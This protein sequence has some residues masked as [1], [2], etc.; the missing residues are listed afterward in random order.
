MKKRKVPET[1]SQSANFH[2]GTRSEYLAHFV[3]SSFGTSVPV[4]HPEDTGI[5]LHCTLTE[6]VG[7]RIWPVEY[8]MV[9]VK[10]TE[11]PWD[12]SSKKSVEQLFKVPLPV[13]FCIVSKKELRLRVYT[14]VNRLSV[15]EK[16][17]DELHLFPGDAHHG[18]PR[19]HGETNKISLGEPIL[20]FTINKIMDPAFARNAKQILY[21]A[22]REDAQQAFLRRIGVPIFETSSHTANE[23]RT[24]GRHGIGRLKLSPEQKE[25]FDHTLRIMLS[26]LDRSMLVKDT[27]GHWRLGLLRRHLETKGSAGKL[28]KSGPLQ[29]TILEYLREKRKNDPDCSLSDNLDTLFD[30]II[31]ALLDEEIEQQDRIHQKR[32]EE[33]EVDDIW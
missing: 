22:V 10:S 16:T 21:R 2:E 19:S 23:V 26:W 24:S 18:V 32:M 5:D 15:L 12:F 27:R 33:G 20:D 29:E 28:R 9:Q 3:F 4:P 30:D 1:G 25:T 7:Q 6:T 17:P 14:T 11:G 31:H 8:Y 13:F